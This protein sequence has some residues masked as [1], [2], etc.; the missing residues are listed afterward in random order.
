MVRMIHS[1]LKNI[2]LNY[3]TELIFIEV[4]RQTV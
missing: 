1:N 4:E 2:D 3:L